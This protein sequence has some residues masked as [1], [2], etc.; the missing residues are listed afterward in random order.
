MLKT[1]YQK[2]V[3]V[4]L[5]CAVV[6]MVLFV[7]VMRHLDV[8]R[9]QELNQK[10]YRNLAAELVREQIV[11]E[12]DGL[13]PREV[14]SVFDRLRKINPRLDVY[15]LDGG[16]HVLTASTGA[17][18]RRTYVD[19]APILRFL[20]DT[21]P[22]PILG[23]DPARS[24]GQ[25][26]FSA[27]PVRLEGQ[28]QGYLYL[29]LRGLVSDSIAQRIRASYVLRES[30][31]IVGLG[32]AFVLLASTLILGLMTRPLQ[33]LN[34]VME[35]LRRGG[36]G[37]GGDGA[38][39]EAGGDEI[40]QI[41]E[42][43]NRMADR[44]LTQMHALKQT[45]SQRRELI[46]NIS[47]DLRTPLASLQG[48]LE[49]LRFKR[50]RLTAEDETAYLQIAL[51]HTEQLG[52]LVAQL[53]ELAK[54]DS[55]QAKIDPEPFVLEELVQDT[56]QQFQ[57]QAGERGVALDIRAPQELPLAYGDIGLIERV[58]R[59][60]IENALRYT[61]AGGSVTVLLHR[62]P[63]GI[64]VEVTDTGRGIDP[65]DLPRIFDGFYR[66]EK[67]RRDAAGHAGLGLAIA[68]RIVEL[69]HRTIS[70]QSRPGET[71][72]RFELPWA[73]SAL[74]AIELPAGAAAPGAQGA[75]GDRPAPAA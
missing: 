15:L 64:G 58:L 8:A 32:L 18:V 9:G 2:L 40:A 70:A 3:A 24:E 55:D 69:H 52:R 54:L 31:S 30:L 48:Y 28:R 43:M 47:H 73:Q 35:K 23:D 71:T 16:G 14:Q 22:L 67:S 50:D 75:F 13:E 19:M 7:L 66:G 44:I 20:D 1:L 38:P 11:P 61:P 59:N 5:A 6:L 56:V 53:F 68:K 49:T 46:A 45:D 65:E 62:A 57:L 37:T 72:I 21:A 41:T 25:R 26:V 63:D 10:L 36:I 60:L 74:P 42:M 33:R 27:A 12:H 29:V 4:L 51:T 39:H 34:A 17:E